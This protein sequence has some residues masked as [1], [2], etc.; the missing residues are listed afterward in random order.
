MCFLRMAIQTCSH[1]ESGLS[2]MCHTDKL[3][4][5]SFPSLSDGISEGFCAR[6]AATTL[7]NIQ[8]MVD[9]IATKREEHF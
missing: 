8:T 3:D 1:I 5:V 2:A 6:A 9:R 4:F 7:V